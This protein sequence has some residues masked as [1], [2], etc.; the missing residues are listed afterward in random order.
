ML[1]RGCR[2]SPAGSNEDRV[3]ELP[4]VGERPGSSRPSGNAEG[5][6]P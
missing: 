4:G 1:K 5:G 3:L 6:G 2:N